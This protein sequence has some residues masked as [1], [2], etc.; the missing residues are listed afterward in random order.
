VDED[1]S[2]QVL[3]V[4]YAVPAWDEKELDAWEGAAR[5]VY[6]KIRVRVQ[7]LDGDALCWLYVLDDYEGGLPSARYLCNLADVPEKAG[8]SDDYVKDLRTRPCKSL[9]D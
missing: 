4:L 9:G 3:V 2:E 6:R 5:D 1:A 7:A 8:P